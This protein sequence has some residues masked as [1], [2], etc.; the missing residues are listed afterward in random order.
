MADEAQDSSHP[1]GTTKMAS[2]RILEMDVGDAI[3]LMDV[4]RDGRLCYIERPSHPLRSQN[5]PAPLDLFMQDNESI[6]SS[7]VQLYIHK[8]K[9]PPRKFLTKV[10]LR[11]YGVLDVPWL[12][13]SVRLRNATIEA[14]EKN[15]TFEITEK[16]TGF[17]GFASCLVVQARE[18]NEFTSWDTAF[19]ELKLSDDDI[20]YSACRN[21]KI[22]EGSNSTVYYGKASDRG[23]SPIA[24]KVISRDTTPTP[25]LVESFVGNRLMVIEKRMYPDSLVACRQV[26]HTPRETQLIMEYVPGPSLQKWLALN[27][28]MNDND[29]YQVFSQVLEA[30]QYLHSLGILHGGIS[31]RSVLLC[32]ANPTVIG[33]VKLIDF[34]MTS[35]KTEPS[36]D[37]FYP[38][39]ELEEIKR[40]VWNN[41]FEGIPPE[42]WNDR[43]ATL[44]NDFWGLGC[45]LYQMLIGPLPV[46]EAVGEPWDRG[47][48]INHRSTLGEYAKLK[49]VDW[50]QEALFPADCEAASRISPNARSIL[51]QLLR[52]EP[53]RRLDSGCI[54]RHP[55]L[56][57]SRTATGRRTARS[58]WPRVLMG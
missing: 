38:E 14:D 34:S 49:R 18:L 28:P 51:F 11:D 2:E 10:V 43:P 4:I 47:G 41:G 46:G 48:K 58:F 55:W 29:A 27:G 17:G 42:I 39:R 36:S 54:N 35:M 24:V 5:G 21:M 37:K 33:P 20:T 9:R 13:S 50:M 44:S 57:M 53:N 16:S 45:L 15:L 1:N 3:E 31:T 7:P 25:A 19:K 22:C 40:C 26:F 6:T 32:E 30:V 12:S 8:E 52:P 56:T 23:N